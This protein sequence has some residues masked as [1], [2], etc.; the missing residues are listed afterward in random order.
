MFDDIDGGVSER[1]PVSNCF[2][3]QLPQSV[4]GFFSR[5]AEVCKLLQF[6]II[7]NRVIAMHE[8]ETVKRH[9]SRTRRDRRVPRELCTKGDSY[10]LPFP[11]GRALRPSTRST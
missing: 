3:C 2:G 5:G 7:W 8:F 6:T 1:L 9:V 4:D 10:F 11:Q